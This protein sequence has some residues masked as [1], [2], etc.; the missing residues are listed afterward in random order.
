MAITGWRARA[1]IILASIFIFP[2]AISRGK[3][4][5]VGIRGFTPARVAAERALEQQL[6]AIP[7]PA[8]AE[9][10]LRHITNEPHMAGTEASHRVAEWLRDQYR[11]YGFDADIV[12][13]SVWLAQPRETKLELT[14]PAKKIL[15]TPEQPFEV[16]PDTSNNN[17]V[18]G[19]NAFSPSG[20]VTAPVVYVN[21]GMQADYRELDKL[22]I[23]VAGKIAIARYGGCYRGIKTKLAE[24][25]QA[26]ALIIYS[27]PED[28]GY[29]A[30][31]VFPNGPWRPM[32]GIQRGSV[33]YTEIYPG[34]PLTPGVAATPDA[35]RLA[36]AEAT[37]LS[38]IP[39]MPINSQ[40]ASAILG[41][42]GGPHV[43][44]QWQGGLPFT[45][46]TGPGTA[47]AHMKL[48]MDYQQRPLYDVIAKLRGTNDGEWI[49]LGN[50]HDAWVYGA[51]DP[52]SGTA[53]MLE[54]ARA[55]GELV[56]AGW[57]PRRTIVM[58][59]WDGE[60][61]GLMGSTEWVEANR[62]ELQAKAVAYLNTDVGVAGPNF[63]ASATPSLKELIRD[64]TREVQDPR[65][66]RSVYNVWLDRATRQQ[67]E[68][69]GIARP[70]S[71]KL[72]APGEAPIEALGAGSDFCP[73]FDHAGIPSLDAGF[74]GDYGVYHSMY[75]D[76]FWMKK[77]GDPS[78]EYHVALAKILGTLALR[79][80][81]SDTLP[82]DYSAYAAEITRV[83]NDLATRAAKLGIGSADVPAV[84][85]AAA[86]LAA[87]AGRASR[88]LQQRANASPNPTKQNELNR[89]LVNVEQSL[90]A[91]NG[92]SGRTWY[93]H[94][95]YA[96]GTYAGYAAEVL[97][98]ANEALDRQDPA[99]FTHE[100]AAL[101]AALRRAS[102]R[103]DEIARTASAVGQ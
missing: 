84:T 92:L 43:P 87:S 28:D 48:V 69:S 5:S 8:R 68:P 86:Q 73:F 19:F 63:T 7:D 82:F 59:E 1:A 11:S 9:G 94:T 39:T 66:V 41:N 29:V 15:A 40:D 93:K 35:K 14:A 4:E 55:F 80:D 56:R 101:A 85:D 54:T 6:R 38:R 25:H 58:C 60:E 31:D 97:P 44:R 70:P 67:E 98:G 57:K 49:V 42:L 37:N 64:V 12:S 18:V 61:P 76:F 88:A 24:E 13:Y 91:P 23:S 99:T 72:T 78:F 62:A 21:Y 52:G 79:L 95:I 32:T 81:E 53:T 75:D 46:H 36:P 71:A 74:I 33:E 83:T 26:L 90:L 51:V 96:P 89:E 27:D 22:G 16:D 100:S 50:H 77:F 45:Y 102:A 65:D 47:V 34:D 10:N 30:G 20:D 103:L 17:I 2:A 3:Q